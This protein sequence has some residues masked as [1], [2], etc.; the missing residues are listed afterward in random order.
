MLK[1]QTKKQQ[2]VQPFSGTMLS[3]LWKWKYGV[4]QR[5]L[6]INNMIHFPY[7]INLLKLFK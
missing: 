7:Q 5:A 6:K 4:S 3:T 1:K 2:R